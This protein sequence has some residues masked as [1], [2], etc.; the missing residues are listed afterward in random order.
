MSADALS[1][2]ALSVNILTPIGHA[3]PKRSAG[4]RVEFFALVGA[5]GIEPAS[6]DLPDPLKPQ[7][8]KDPDDAP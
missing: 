5:A 6:A 3:G 4:R 1:Q 8:N 7:E 2:V